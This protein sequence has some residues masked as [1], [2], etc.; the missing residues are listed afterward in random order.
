MAGI[1]AILVANAKDYLNWVDLAYAM[2][3]DGMD[4]SITPLFAPVQVSRPYKW[5]NWVA[6]RELEMLKGGYLFQPDDALA[7]EA[8]AGRRTASRLAEMQSAGWAK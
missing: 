7:D 3:L 1:A 8:F 4:S 5:I 2:D 6:A